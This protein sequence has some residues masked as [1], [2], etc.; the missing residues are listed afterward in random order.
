MTFLYHITHMQNLASIVGAGGLWCDALLAG[1]VGAGVAGMGIA[2]K[3]IKARRAHREV[4][5]GAGGTLADYV[6]F[7][8][9][10][11]SPMLYAVFKGAVA[12]YSGGQDQVVHLIS[13]VDV[14][15][16]LGAAWFFT[17]GHAEIVFSQQ[18]GT[19]SDLSRVDWDI[20]NERFW[21]D[22]IDDGDRKRRRKAEF[23]VHRFVPWTAVQAIGVRSDAAA[24]SVQASIAHAVHRPPVVV[25]SDWYY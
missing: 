8:F 22:T 4:V 23:L 7:Y 20:M 19:L 25:R 12:G 10:P 3:H 6:P 16:A 18:F 13:S 2:H 21:N 14:A 15:V 1:K 17:D 24:R 9:A 5:K 11:R